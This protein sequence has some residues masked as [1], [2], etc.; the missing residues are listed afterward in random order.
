MT[1]STTAFNARNGVPKTIPCT[2]QVASLPGSP[3]FTHRLRRRASG[4]EMSDFLERLTSN[5]V[6][7]TDVAEKEARRFEA[8]QYV[9]GKLMS[10]DVEGCGVEGYGDDDGMKPS[11][12]VAFFTANKLGLDDDTLA[13]LR[14]HVSNA[15]SAWLRVMT[16]DVSFR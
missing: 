1:D 10:D 5:T 15:I 2:F 11:E 13:E 16:G 12:C 6:G 14:S 9:Y 3:V 8:E 4:V 7:T